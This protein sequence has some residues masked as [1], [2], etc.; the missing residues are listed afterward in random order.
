VSY[1]WSDG[2]NSLG[3][4][5][6]ISASS[7]GTYTVTVTGANGCVATSSQVI[8]QNIT[9]PNAAI[10]PPTTSILTCSTP[11]IN[12][13]GT[14]GGTYSWFDGSSVIGTTAT[15]TVSAANTYILTVTGANGCDATTSITITDNFSTPTPSINASNTILTCNTT[16]ITLVASGGGT[17]AWTGGS[18]AASLV[19]TTPGSYTV[20][21]TSPNGCTA[22]ANQVITQNITAPTAS[23]SSTNNGQLT[24]A[25]TSITLTATGG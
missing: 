12:L 10:T 20:T 18:T 2:T 1:A 13:T 15:V 17:Y 22:T 25:V 23:I 6:L 14:G 16:S 24:C 3:T 4:T 5:S 8:T 21:V 7:P 19:V 11:T 9:P